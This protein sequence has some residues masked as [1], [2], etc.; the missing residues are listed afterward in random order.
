MIKL[1]NSMLLFLSIFIAQAILIKISKHIEAPSEQ[2]NQLRPSKCNYST[3]E[4]SISPSLTILKFNGW[5]I[6]INSCGKI[7]VKCMKQS[8]S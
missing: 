1:T 3:T 4:V 5:D 2:I 8:G 6:V 7:I